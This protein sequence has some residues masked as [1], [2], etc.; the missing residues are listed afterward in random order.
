MIV[1][2]GG[3]GFIGS[4]VIQELNHRGI[5][6]I[7][8]VDDLTIGEKFNTLK[9][10][11]FSRYIDID[12]VDTIDLSRVK[13]VFHCGGI[14]S[15]VENNGKLLM[16]Q[17]Y[18]STVE[19]AHYCELYDIPMVYLSSA[20][21]YGNSNT[22]VE[23]DPVDP[24][25]PYAYSKALSEQSVARY[26]NV[27]VFRPFNVYGDGEEYKGNQASPISKFKIQH[28]TQGY[29]EVFDGSHNIRRDFICVDDVVKILVDYTEKNPGLYNLGTGETESFYNIAK[30]ISD[31]V[32]EIEFPVNLKDKYQYYSC[33]DTTKLKTLIGDYKFIKVKEYVIFSN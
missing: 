11:K 25:N 28:Q 23:S 22:F 16:K 5:N 14:S 3:A 7:I 12:S 6:N 19:W 33:A 10:L 32:R 2:T 24:L 30:M 27:W 18:E 4:R 29:V 9:K 15:T 31:D 26:N 17:N 8:I 1:V 20:S 21:V 13:K